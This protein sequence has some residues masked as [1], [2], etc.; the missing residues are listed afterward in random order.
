LKA[1]HKTRCT[2]PDTC[3][4]R[5]V[6]NVVY[7]SV[8]AVRVALQQNSN[9]SVAI[10]LL[11]THRHYTIHGFCILIPKMKDCVSLTRFYKG[12]HNYNTVVL[13]KCHYSH[14][15]SKRSNRQGR[16]FVFSL[17]QRRARLNMKT[18]HAGFVVDNVT[19]R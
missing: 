15:Q 13:Y 17:S 1:L 19:L 4:S 12:D 11:R 14:L 2:Q 8:T 5:A 6:P 7:T 16:P 9:N 10:S 18:V 3:A